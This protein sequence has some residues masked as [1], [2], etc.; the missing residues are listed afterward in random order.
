MD[1]EVATPFVFSVR[2]RSTP[3]IR[4]STVNTREP[5]KVPKISVVTDWEGGPK[6][7]TK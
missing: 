7:I 6:G 4:W 1:L 3:H 5:H 2:L